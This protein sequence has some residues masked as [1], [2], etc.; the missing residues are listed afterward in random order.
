MSVY[1]PCTRIW[2]RSKEITAFEVI[3]LIIIIIA[4]AWIWAG[5][6]SYCYST[7]HPP[8]GT[9]SHMSLAW[10]QHGRIYIKYLYRSL[11]SCR[12]CLPLLQT[13]FSHGLLCKAYRSDVTDFCHWWLFTKDEVTSVRT[14]S[15]HIDFC[16]CFSTLYLMISGMFLLIVMSQRCVYVCFLHAIVSTK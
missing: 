2:Q 11:R 7:I 12:R 3:K 15:Q 5:M 4:Q 13:L 1:F 9:P 6:I 8:A 10:I 16:P 14:W